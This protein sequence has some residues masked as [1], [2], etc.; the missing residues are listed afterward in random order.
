VIFADGGARLVG[1][2]ALVVATAGGWRRGLAP[3]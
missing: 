1:L 2:V 3:R